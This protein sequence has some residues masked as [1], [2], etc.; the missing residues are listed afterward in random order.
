MNPINT[1]DEWH[2][3]A[4]FI[5]SPLLINTKISRTKITY[6]FNTLNKC[7]GHKFFNLKINVDIPLDKSLWINQLL[8]NKNHLGSIGALYQIAQLINYAYDLG[9]IFFEQIGKL[10]NNPQNLKTYFY[11]LFIFYR[12]DIAN[13]PNNKKTQIGKQE[14]E[15]LCEINHNTFLFECRKVFMP[16]IHELDTAKRLMNIFYIKSRKSNSL[17]PL[18]C[19][20]KFNRPFQNNYR[21]LFE[22]KIAKFFN[23]LNRNNLFL[24]GNYLDVDQCGILEAKPYSESNLVEAKEITNYDVL[25]FIIPSNK[26]NSHSHLRAG[27]ESSFRVYQSTIDQKLETILK[28]KKNQHRNSPFKNKIIFIDTEI[29]PTMDLDLF[30]TEASFNPITIEKIHQKVCKND[31]I[32]FTRR[33]FSTEEPKTETIVFYPEH[34]KTEAL[35]LQQVFTDA[36]KS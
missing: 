33:T 20:I 2:N 8:A 3:N 17:V 10:R 12:L 19:G 6:I 13:I 24:D 35:Y 26:Y 31:I 23:K 36:T 9:P 14:I 11:E 18:I 25:F 27:M 28:E 32:C 5:S 16:K 4:R 34:L 21:Y 7:F 30:Q 15:G 29:Y 22:S 1:L